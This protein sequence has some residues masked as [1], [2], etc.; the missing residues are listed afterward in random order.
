MLPFPC[1]WLP[2][3][4]L[5]STAAAGLCSVAP[6]ETCAIPPVRLQITPSRCAGSLCAGPP[7]RN[8]LLR[9][10]GLED[11][12]T[13]TEIMEIG[14]DVLKMW[15]VSHKETVE[16]A[17]AG[18]ASNCSSEHAAAGGL[19]EEKARTLISDEL[20]PK[21]QP[22]AA[23]GSA[24]EGP[25]Q[26]QRGEGLSAQGGPSSAPSQAR[27]LDSCV[28]HVIIVSMICNI[29][30]SASTSAPASVQLWRVHMPVSLCVRVRVRAC[31]FGTRNDTTQRK[32]N[33][34]C[35]CYAHVH[36]H[37]QMS[38]GDYVWQ[39]CWQMRR[40]RRAEQV[41]RATASTATAA[42]LQRWRATPPRQTC[43]RREY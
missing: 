13:P 34:R 23:A 28:V 38:F 31:T 24:T 42:R 22:T 26:E 18:A 40:G 1:H 17:A 11:Q 7:A 43:L 39:P 2:V 9:G 14:N 5:L 16:S 8:I 6:P 32:H 37:A 15:E 12:V 27:G 25:E 29:S 19:S 20:H 41:T 33:N 4:M 3:A 21:P 10:G 36:D 30:M 35:K